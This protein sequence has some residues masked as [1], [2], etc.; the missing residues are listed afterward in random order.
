MADPKYLFLCC[1]VFKQTFRNGFAVWKTEWS[2]FFT[3][4]TD[5]GF[6]FPSALFPCKGFVCVEVSLLRFLLKMLLC[7]VIYCGFWCAIRILG[8]QLGKLEVQ[9]RSFS[10]VPSSIFCLI[11]GQQRILRL[12]FSSDAFSGRKKN[13]LLCSFTKHVWKH[14][15]ADKILIGFNFYFPWAV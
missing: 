14:E 1:L 6:L 7:W 4:I 2:L 9:K 8:S 13:Q 10:L 5:I 15:G 12:E 11:N 3:S